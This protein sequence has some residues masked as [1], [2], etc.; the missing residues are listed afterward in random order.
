MYSS[1]YHGCNGWPNSISQPNSFDRS[2][3]KRR[4]RKEPLV[5]GISNSL[6]KRYVRSSSSLK[7]NDSFQIWT[8]LAEIGWFWDLKTTADWHFVCV[9]SDVYGVFV[10]ETTSSSVEEE[11]AL[12]KER[13]THTHTDRQTDMHQMLLR[14][15]NEWRDNQRERERE[16]ERE[17]GRSRS[18]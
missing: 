8:S 4:R 1:S 12:S 15:S 9:A 11:I 14:P 10:E 18:R 2:I 7:N 5:I 17:R 3:L 13:E 16:R 6:A